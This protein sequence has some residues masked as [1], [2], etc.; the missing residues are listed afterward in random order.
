[1]FRQKTAMTRAWRRAAWCCL[2][3]VLLAAA[4]P[5]AANA[6][7]QSSEYAVVCGGELD[8][9]FFAHVTRQNLIIR[10]NQQ[11]FVPVIN[12]MLRDGW[13]LAGGISADAIADSVTGCQTM[14]KR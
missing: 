12:E 1:M 8:G 13:Q 7:G 9:R 3:A 4:L 11:G 6:S 2:P 14:V 10:K 5:G